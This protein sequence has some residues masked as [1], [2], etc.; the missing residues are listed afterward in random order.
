MQSQ[1]DL[2]AP[3]ANFAGAV[4]KA[5]QLDPNDWSVPHAAVEAAFSERTKLVLIN[6][7][8]KCVSSLGVVSTSEMQ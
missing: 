4:I 1:Y 2:Y 8:H 6:S 3:A 5:V 7:P